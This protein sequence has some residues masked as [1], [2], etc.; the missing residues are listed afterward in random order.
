MDDAE[1][2]TPRMQ[3]YAKGV[4]TH[5]HSHADLDFPPETEVFVHI[6]GCA[7]LPAEPVRCC[8]MRGQ[9]QGRKQRNQLRCVYLQPEKAQSAPPAP[10][11]FPQHPL[12]PDTA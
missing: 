3:S 1:A 12:F 4:Y 10:T 8:G 6:W 5:M 11:L 9:F 2:Q 7:E